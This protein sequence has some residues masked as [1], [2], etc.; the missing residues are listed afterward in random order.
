[1]AIH[2]WSRVP[3]GVFHDLHLGWVVTLASAMNNGVL[4][5]TCY[6]MIEPTA[7]SDWSDVA[8]VDRDRDQPDDGSNEDSPLVNL[9]DDPPRV[10]FAMTDEAAW[11]R[12][13]QN[14]V[15]I[16]HSSDD[17][18]IALIEIVSPGNKSSRH[19]L[20]TPLSRRRPKRSTVATTC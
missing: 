8:A 3:A 1:M 7:P 13:K 4:P 2:D 19:A 14:S 16:R 10:R 11:Y 17:R 5:P 18:I 12:R 9:W 6:A 20:R 15:V